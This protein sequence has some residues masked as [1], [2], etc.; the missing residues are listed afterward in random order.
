MSWL[1]KLF[2]YGDRVEI[3]VEDADVTLTTNQLVTTLTFKF[4][5]SPGVTRVITAPPEDEGHWVL[6]NSCTDTSSVTIQSSISGLASITLLSGE[7][8]LVTF[9]RTV[10]W[11]KVLGFD[12]ARLPGIGF[13]ASGVAVGSLAGASG[14]IVGLAL[15]KVAA[16]ASQAGRGWA[17]VASSA[18]AGAS[19]AGAA[20]GGGFEWIAGNA[21]RFTSGDADGGGFLYTVGNGIGTGISGAFKIITAA[22][23]ELFRV[24]S[25]GVFA[26]AKLYLGGTTAS[27]AYSTGAGA[28]AAA[29]GNG[30]LRAR[31]DATV[32]DHAIE[33]RMG[34]AWV[35]LGGGIAPITITNADHVLTS[36]EYAKKIIELTNEDTTGPH[37]TT[38]P[39]GVIAWWLVRNRMAESHNI[40]V[41][42]GSPLTV[43]DGETWIVYSDG[44][45]LIG[46]KLTP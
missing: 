20:V 3:D 4:T 25:T 39:A 40:K 35:P 46:G 27:P 30:S 10:G 19:V 42:G 24:D 38:F 26:T 16:A 18:T 15:A 12:I 41:A 21:A 34:G 43:F 45:D 31:T 44:S 37:V 8:A 23:S 17:F 33:T 2:R 7:V 36:A 13:T 14:G 32:Q 11:V 5:G 9:D 29:D 1:D 6:W 22:A 28:A